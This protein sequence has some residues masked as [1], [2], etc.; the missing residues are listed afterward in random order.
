MNVIAY[1]DDVAIIARGKKSL[2]GV[3]QKQKDEAGK[4]GLE[5]N[6]D[7]TNTRK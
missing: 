2:E 1:A 6:Q 5:M 3:L 7:K 4:M